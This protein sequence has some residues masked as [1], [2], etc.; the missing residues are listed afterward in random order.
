MD[1]IKTSE[2]NYLVYRYMTELGYLHS[3]YTFKNETELSL[4]KFSHSEVEKGQL[5]SYIYKGLKFFELE[6]H[7][8]RQT[9]CKDPFSIVQK[10]TCKNEKLNK[11]QTLPKKRKKPNITDSFSKTETSSEESLERKKIHLIEN[12]SPIEIEIPSLAKEPKTIEVI[13]NSV[14]GTSCSW[15][16]SSPN[17]LLSTFEDGQAIILEYDTNTQLTNR[18]DLLID[19]IPGKEGTITCSGWSPDGDYVAT[20]TYNGSC[21]IWDSKGNFQ[22]SIKEE[23]DSVIESDRILCLKWNHERTR[24][25]LGKRSGRVD[26]GDPLNEDNKITKSFRIHNDAI[27]DLDWGI[28]GLFATC[29]KDKT[30]I[31]YNE[32]NVEYHLVL[33]GH[34]NDV[35]SVRWSPTHNELASGSD[36]G[37][38][39]IWDSKTGNILFQLEEHTEPVLIVRWSPDGSILATGSYDETICLW[40]NLN[41]KLLQTLQ[42]HNGTINTLEFSSDGLYII[43]GSSDDSLVLWCKE[44]DIYQMKNHFLLGGEA[45]EAGWSHDNTMLAACTESGSTYVIS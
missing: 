31:I 44:N 32:S 37:T 26:I 14:R 5:I 16:P 34:K 6:T 3:A 28:D 29:S 11:Q 19:D 8:I 33:N 43:S 30:V 41:G 13:S 40:S 20:G 23:G 39:I 25:L 42:G 21:N 9:K 4:S 2:I 36:D 35:N 45:L 24:I 7:I 17:R 15:S 1:K 22:A 12:L 10:H 18:I 27:F 38:A